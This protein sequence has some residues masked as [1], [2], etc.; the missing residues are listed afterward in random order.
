MLE[1][2][3]IRGIILQKWNFQ[4]Q[5]TSVCGLVP[6]GSRCGPVEDQFEQLTIHVG[7]IKFGRFLI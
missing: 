2:L 1:D 6:S 5:V 4:K 3:C 7:F